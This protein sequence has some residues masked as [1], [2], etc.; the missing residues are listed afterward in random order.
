[1]RETRGSQTA[2]FMALFRVLE[3]QRAAGTRLFDDP[4]AVGFLGP[5]LRFV[6]WLSRNPLLRGLITRLIDALWPGARSAGVARTRL[7]DDAL[8]RALDGGGFEQVVLLG[9][10][11]DARAHR[12]PCLAQMPVFEVDHP[13]TL[14]E[15]QRR[16]ESHS[17]SPTDRSIYVALDFNRQPLG[18]ALA[19]AGFDPNRCAF[20][21]LEGVTNY[22]TAE[23]VDS[24]LRFVGSTAPRSRLLF[25][26]V[27]RDVLSATSRFPGAWLLRR[28]LRRASEPWTFGLDPSRLDSYLGE[29]GLVLVRDEG[30][31]EYRER[32]LGGRERLLEGYEFYRAAIADVVP[33][34]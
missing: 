2:Q 34:P 13:N 4:F 14:E 20:F 24:L 18:D 7:I 6:A 12:L 28:T 23:A 31:R 8:D 25:T 17:A 22:L 33:R 9:A 1:M 10:G 19:K 27:H 11:F 16:I 21:V 26:Y 15:K 3:S 29:R 32:Y 5:G 30:S